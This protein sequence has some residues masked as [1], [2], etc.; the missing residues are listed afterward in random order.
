MFLCLEMMG[1]G[2][3]EPTNFHFCRLS[4]NTKVA[5]VFSSKVLVDGM[6]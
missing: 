1:G 4:G 3:G 2:G 5:A 6:C